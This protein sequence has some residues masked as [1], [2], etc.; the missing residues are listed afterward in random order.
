MDHDTKRFRLPRL[1][2][3][4][5]EDRDQNKNY[6][7]LDHLFDQAVKKSRHKR[8]TTYASKK[9]HVSG[10]AYTSVRKTPRKVEQMKTSEVDTQLVNIGLHQKDVGQWRQ[11]QFEYKQ[12]LITK[13]PDREGEESNT[14]FLPN[15]K[16]LGENEEASAAASVEVEE[17]DQATSIETAADA[18]SSDSSFEKTGPDRNKS[19]LLQALLRF[20]KVAQDQRPR[21]RE[22]AAAESTGT[23]S[24]D[25][26][27]TEETEEKDEDVPDGAVQ[28]PESTSGHETHDLDDTENFGLIDTP[29]PEPERHEIEGFE[30]QEEELVNRFFQEME[31]PEPF[32]RDEEAQASREPESFD[33]GLISE[34]PLSAN[35]DQGL[36]YDENIEFEQEPSEDVSRKDRSRNLDWDEDSADLLDENAFYAPFNLDDSDD[37]LMQGSDEKSAA[38]DDDISP[39]DRPESSQTEPTETEKKPSPEEEAER[40]KRREVLRQKIRSQKQQG[41][42]SEAAERGRMAYATEKKSMDSQPAAP[43]RSGRALFREALEDESIRKAFYIMLLGLILFVAFILVFRSGF[44]TASWVMAG[45]LLVVLILTSDTNQRSTLIMLFLT[46][47]LFLFIEFYQIF[48]QGYAL[49]L[50]DYLWFILT[51]ICTMTCFAFFHDYRAWKKESTAPLMPIQENRDSEKKSDSAE[52]KTDE[53]DLTGADDASDDH[54]IR[55]IRRE[56]SDPAPDESASF[57]EPAV[58]EAEEE[59]L[60]IREEPTD[61][62]DEDDPH[63]ETQE[64]LMHLMNLE[65]RKGSS[66]AASDP[67]D[68]EA[69]QTNAVSETF[70]I[71]PPE[72]SEVESFDEE[73][74]DDSFSEEAVFE[75]E[76]PEDETSDT[77]ASKEASSE[78]SPFAFKPES[79]ETEEAKIEEVQTEAEQEPQTGREEN[80]DDEHH[81]HPTDHFESL[82]QPIQII[83]MSPDELYANTKETDSE[84]KTDEKDDHSV[85]DNA[86]IATELSDLHVNVNENHTFQNESLTEQEA[87]KF[88]QD[89]SFFFESDDDDK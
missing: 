36:Y 26:L 25:V 8:I 71:T 89:Y 54:V 17:T 46:L 78:E 64:I 14:D 35:F 58:A 61:E 75:E 44:N 82:T 11:S 49:H 23:D 28:P 45:T 62:S 73:G 9:Q 30:E 81:D 19:E 34:K 2:S 53:P 80:E 59:S 5:K 32:G 52:A 83:P 57:D 85:H 15:L 76:I 88:E 27:K 68:I 41:A 77:E 65:N 22:S 60:F 69:A 74:P 43:Y 13:Q 6:E 40:K 33:L 7:D 48:A 37:W 31:I 79:D 24:K 20:E 42:M 67:D 51:P 3:A 56:E 4:D 63:S 86:W 50:F 39:D 47:V 70:K 29:E 21:A 55:A 72:T 16:S 66:K 12:N 87:K 10:P 84:A 1:H 18:G 38:S